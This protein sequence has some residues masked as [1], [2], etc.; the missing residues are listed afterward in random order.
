MGEVASLPKLEM[1]EAG[2]GAVLAGMA[3]RSQQ[4]ETLVGAEAGVLAVTVEMLPFPLVIPLAEEEAGAAELDP[5]LQLELRL[6][7]AMGAQI[8]TLDKMEMGMVFRLQLARA[9]AG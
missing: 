6:T 5:A 2:A 4:L 8:K 7:W 1:K 9:A 3:A